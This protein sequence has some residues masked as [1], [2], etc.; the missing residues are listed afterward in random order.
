[1]MH[2][3]QPIAPP[4]FL[5]SQYKGF[6]VYESILLVTND[7]TE[8]LTLLSLRLLESQ[9]LYTHDGS[10]YSVCVLPSSPSKDKYIA[11]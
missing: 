5:I 2:M 10:R 4:H 11:S 1:M 9:I 8:S 6:S 3:S 7:E